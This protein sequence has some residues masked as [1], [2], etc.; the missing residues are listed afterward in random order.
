MAQLRRAYAR[1]VEA[2]RDVKRGVYDD[3]LS[4][5]MLI[6][7]LAAVVPPRAA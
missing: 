1:L 4:L 2:D 5:E 3:R 7:D 6:A